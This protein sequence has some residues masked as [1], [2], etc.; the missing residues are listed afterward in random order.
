VTTTAGE[1]Q[2]QEGKVTGDDVTFAVARRVGR[3]EV[4]LIYTGKL[5]DDVLVM[6]V[7]FPG[8][9]SRMRMTARR[10]P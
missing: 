1:Q 8:E 6:E 10:L 5:N 2:I 9:E 4:K 3:R 7:A